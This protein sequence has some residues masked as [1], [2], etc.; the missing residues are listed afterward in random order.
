MKIGNSTPEENNAKLVELLGQI[1]AGV[2]EHGAAEA[3]WTI[4]AEDCG[5]T[6][7]RYQLD[8]TLNR[9]QL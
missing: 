7:F 1:I 5:D 8:V 4:D 3:H 9:G 2:L 6:P